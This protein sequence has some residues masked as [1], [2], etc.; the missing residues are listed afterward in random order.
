MQ[1]NDINYLKTA[2]EAGQYRKEGNETGNRESDWDYGCGSDIG[3][4]EWGELSREWSVCSTGAAQSPIR[5]LSFD[6]AKN[7]QKD[8]MQTMHHPAPATVVNDGNLIRLKW[9]GGF[10]YI[11]DVLYELRE[12]QFHT[13]SEHTINGK[14]YPLEMQMIHNSSE[15]GGMVILSILFKLDKKGNKFLDQFWPYIPSFEWNQE[16]DITGDVEPKELNLNRQYFY[17]Y[18]GSLTYPP[19]TE[20]VR[21]MV[22]KKIRKVSPMQV[23]MLYGALKHENSRPTQALNGRNV[24]KGKLV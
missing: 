5:I 12:T 4:R 8:Y 6:I 21:W 3:P 9:K 23:D 10:L 2:I 7:E 24:Y 22:L 19:C 18:R 13:P 14:K 11:D 17:Q 16:V 1:R 20:G 15:N